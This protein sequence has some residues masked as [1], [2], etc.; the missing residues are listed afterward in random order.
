MLIKYNGKEYKTLK[1]DLYTIFPG[2]YGGNQHLGNKFVSLFG[3]GAV[4]LATY[5]AY[6]KGEPLTK[7]ELKSKQQ[8]IFNKYMLGPIS[9]YRFKLGTHLFFGLFKDKKS[10]VKVKY[11]LSSNIRSMSST[12]KLI[13]QSID[14]DIPVPLI[15]GLKIRNGY[16]DNLKSH[17]VTITGYSRGVDLLISNNGR[18]ESIKLDKLIKNRLF[19]ATI[20]INKK[21]L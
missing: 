3:C 13:K 8:K 7:E 14:S 4:S 17:W 5:D 2:I 18:M 10:V 20:Y 21:Y 19:V 6:M 12:L 1:K 15:V 16:K 9:A 11:N